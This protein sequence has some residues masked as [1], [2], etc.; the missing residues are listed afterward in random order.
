MSDSGSK[1]GEADRRTSVS[2]LT[3]FDALWDYEQPGPTER[4]FREL[5]PAALD[6]LDISY[7]AE[8]LTQ[9][10]RAEAMQKKF[11]EAQKTLDRV[12]KALPKADQRVSVRYVLERGRVLSLSGK[13]REAQPRLREAFNL[14]LMLKMDLHAIDAARMMAI[15]EP[16]KALEWNMKA[17]DLAE[18]SADA[19][20]NKAKGPLYS[21]IG[22]NHFERKE[23]QEALF[24]FQK[25]LES[26][27]QLGDPL[28]IRT[29]KW[30]VAKVLRVIKHTEEALE[31]Q[32]KLFEEYQGEGKRN[33]YVYEEIAECLLILGQEQEA[34][35]WFA[36]AYAELSKDPRLAREQN[37]LTRLKE[38]G[39]V[40][41]PRPPA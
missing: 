3:D 13:P 19:R 39:Q 21:S 40:G 23:Y 15:A 30:P 28:K 29:A 38:L 2:K 27:E 33:G 36:A 35:E 16:E 10:A 4:K 25:Y 17:L 32:R 8:L 14:A 9:I 5:L 20:A 11:S 18:K 24:M 26:C 37:R 7:L 12:E 41:R 31:M 22:W 1:M 6:S 34:Q